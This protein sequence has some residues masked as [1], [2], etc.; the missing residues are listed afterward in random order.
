V[1]SNHDARALRLI[2]IAND[3]LAI[4]RSL[5]LK[6]DS[7]TENESAMPQLGDA[8]DLP[9]FTQ[10]ARQAYRDRR[11]RDR[12]FQADDLF[13]EPAWDIL[14]DL[15]VAAKERRRISVTSACIGAAVPPTTALRWIAILERAGLVQR[16]ADSAD[17]RRAYVMLSPTG[18]A[19]MVQYFAETSVPAY[20]ADERREER[21]DWRIA[22]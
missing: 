21:E 4:A 19:K 12:I 6:S 8:L 16:E 14:L 2:A 18:Y 5:E 3:L 10:H 9:I 15:F 7:A 17:G 22:D 13:G 1:T 11:W 20:P